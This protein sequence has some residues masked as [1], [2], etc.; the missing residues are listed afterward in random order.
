MVFSYFKKR[1]KGNYKQTHLTEILLYELLNDLLTF[2]GY[3]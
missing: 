2:S 1:R 3:Y